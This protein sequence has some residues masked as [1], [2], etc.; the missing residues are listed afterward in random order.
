MV[1]APRSRRAQAAFSRTTKPARQ[2]VCFLVEGIG[3]ATRPAGPIAELDGSPDYEF[4]A[5][6]S[7][8]VG[9]AN[10][11]RSAAIV[12]GINIARAPTAR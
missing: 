10:R 4:R 3:S 8:S 1:I 12:I 7:S 9:R 5:S 11:Q 2:K 6:R